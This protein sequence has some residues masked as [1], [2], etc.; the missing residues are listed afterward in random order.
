MIPWLHNDLQGRCAVTHR[1]WLTLPG[2]VCVCHEYCVA[3]VGGASAQMPFKCRLTCSAWSHSARVA[4]HS[5]AQPNPHLLWTPWDL[6]RTPTSS[7]CRT[8]TRPTPW[9]S[10]SD[11]CLKLTRRDSTSSGTTQSKPAENTECDLYELCETITVCAN[12][13]SQSSQIP[14]LLLHLPDCTQEAPLT[15]VLVCSNSLTLK[16]ESGDIL[17]DYSKNLITD[18]VMKMLVDLVIPSLY[19]NHCRRHPAPVTY[20]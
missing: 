14:P 15:C 18:E 7:G 8:G 19:S 10:T 9:I 17:L 20:L 11:T 5:G 6:R 3:L 13:V 16:T 12:A 1:H 4:D 2:C